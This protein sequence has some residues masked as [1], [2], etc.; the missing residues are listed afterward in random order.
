MVR[1]IP[2][3]SCEG[4][5][6]LPKEPRRGYESVWGDEDLQIYAELGFS[7][8]GVSGLGARFTAP[9]ENCRA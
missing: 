2:F 4:V 5:V 7:W 6:R 1:S 3:Q 9:S 8:E